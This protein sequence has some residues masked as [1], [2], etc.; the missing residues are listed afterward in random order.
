MKTIQEVLLL[1]AEYLAKR[2]L[3]NVRREAEEA[4]SLG[5][6]LPRI[7]LYMHFDRP[8][9]EVELEQCRNYL[10]RRGKGE[11]YAYIQG[12]AEF[13][14]C[15]FSLNSAVL[16]PRQETEI[17]VDKIA[18]TLKQENRQGKILW[19]LCCGSGCIGISL[20]KCHP[21]LELVMSDICPEAL[22]VAK[23]NMEANAVAGSVLQGNLFEAYAGK[24]D[25]F[26]CNPPYI[27]EKE[28]ESLELE[29]KGYEPKK[30]LVAEQDGLAFYHKI[31]VELKAR[32]TP[33]GKAWME[34]G[35]Q[36]GRQ[37]LEIF[38]EAGWRHCRLEKD[39]AG[40]DR[41]FSLEN[42]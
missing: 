34:I 24:C 2:G 4:L 27:S 26:V 22:L 12:T 32:L 5:L 1:S 35:Y 7:D 8:V 15:Q 3:K 11:P 16:I 28:Y 39:W 31:A 10:V 36:Q 17:L 23:K 6:K 41:F 18:N 14:S 37:V 38:K 13:Y 19:D 20:K 42:E 40:H 29:V 33:G 30:A 25:Y 9:T 21:E